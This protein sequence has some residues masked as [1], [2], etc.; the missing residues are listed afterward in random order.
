MKQKKQ[1]NLFDSIGLMYMKSNRPYETCLT[2]E[3]WVI[4]FE[5]ER[6]SLCFA[7]ISQNMHTIRDNNYRQTKS[8]FIFQM[9]IRYDMSTCRNAETL[10]RNVYL[11]SVS[12]VYVQID[13]LEPES[14]QTCHFVCQFSFKLPLY[15]GIL[16][17][18]AHKSD[19]DSRI[20]VNKITMIVK[21]KQYRYNNLG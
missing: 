10:W 1:P 16:I 7:E 12:I 13:L 15:D 19:L 11:C 21:S 2:E 14:K 18:I 9:S 5:V 6:R 3:F 17:W 20:N 8:N 4:R